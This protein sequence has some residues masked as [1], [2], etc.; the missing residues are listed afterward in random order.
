MIVYAKMLDSYLIITIF[1]I[2]R[3]IYKKLHEYNLYQTTYL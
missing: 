1:P 3:Y 2:K